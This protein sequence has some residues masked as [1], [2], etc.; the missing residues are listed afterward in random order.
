G[1]A[2]FETLP[3]SLGGACEGVLTRRPSDCAV[4]AG[5]DMVDPAPL[6][7]GCD[8]AAL[9]VDAGRHD[10]AVVAAGDDAIRVR[11]RAEN[12]AAMR[13]HRARLAR[14]RH[15]DER[16]LAQHQDRNVAEKVRAH[17]SCA[18]LDRPRAL[19]HGRNIVAGFGHSV[20]AGAFAHTTR[21][22]TLLIVPARAYS[23]LTPR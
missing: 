15:Q 16:L 4:R 9:A 2:R 14:A 11:A 23:P 7:V 10:L 1:R 6:D 5:R 20:T 12:R 8:H 22:A 3:G 18:G 19:D 13:R 17:D 21:A